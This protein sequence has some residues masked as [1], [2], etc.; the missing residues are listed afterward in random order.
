MTP[1]GIATRASQWNRRKTVIDLGKLRS[2]CDARIDSFASLGESERTAH[3][4]LSVFIDNGASVL[5]VAHLDTVY[6]DKTWFF[7]DEENV[8]CP[9][10]DDRLGVYLLLD[11]IHRL[12]VKCDILLTD[13]EES[14]LSSAQGWSTDKE[15]N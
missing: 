2:I 1:C 7:A 13:G 9:R 15:Y 5:G 10:L 4:K 14:M 12:G 8:Y 6:P 11:V 3:G